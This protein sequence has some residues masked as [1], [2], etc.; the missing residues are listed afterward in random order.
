M[1]KVIASAPGKLM[2]FGEHAVVYGY[3]C[4]VAAVDQRFHAVLEETDLP[5]LVL[6]APDL[7][8]SEYRKKFAD[9]GEGEIDKKVAF[10]ET[11]VK[12]FLQ[13]FPQSQGVKISTKNDFSVNF[14]FGSSSA[15]AVA[16]LKG[17][18]EFYEIKL[19]NDQIFN[20]AYQVVM[21][22][23][24]VGS[25][26][27]VAAA[28]YGGIIYYV[29]PINAN[30]QTKI[31]KRIE[32]ETLP[33]LVAY[34]GIKADTATLVKKVAH[35]FQNKPKKLEE[36]FKQIQIIV[37]QASTALV[38]RDPLLL[39]NLMKKNQS[40]LSLLGISSREIEETI[41][42]ATDN[43]A[44]AG[45]LSGAGGGDCVLLLAEEK[46]KTKITAAVNQTPAE[47][48]PVTLGEIGVQAYTE[49][50][51]SYQEEYEKSYRPSY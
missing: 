47:I 14:G 41:K 4:I 39:S 8:I 40:L 42:A 28:V 19:N 49:T 29:R 21:E 31:V 10:A 11:A 20:L 18:S 23:Q 35:T 12:I 37:E 2:L 17:L 33:F 9:L 15:S 44:M 6:H 25:G 3:P 38:N 34:T 30:P 1:K 5:Q 45:K 22:V 16:I 13:L 43:G 7:Q 27:D 36:I 46:D 24:G 32:T 26:F 50:I 51:N 48:L